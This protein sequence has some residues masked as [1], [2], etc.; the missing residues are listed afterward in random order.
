MTSYKLY[1][2]NSGDEVVQV[3]EV[4]TE[5]QTAI[6]REHENFYWVL[7]VSG[8]D[9]EIKNNSTDK[10]TVT[11]SVVDGLEVARGTD[12]HDANMLDYDGDVTLSIDGSETTKTLSSG[13][14]SFDL[15]TEKSAGSTIE[16]V[17]ESLLEHPA[18]SDRIEI[19]VVSA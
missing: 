16:I 18:E 9:R 19:E 17:A 1:P 5:T 12:K 14:V 11:I 3:R 13:S 15:T 2:D 7:A 10:E 4:E 6:I 8:Q